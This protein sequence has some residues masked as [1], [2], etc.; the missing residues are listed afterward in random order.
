MTSPARTSR[1]KSLSH[2]PRRR[3]GGGP[4]HVRARHAETGLQRE[5]RVRTGLEIARDVHVTEEIAV[6][7]V[8]CAAEGLDRASHSC[9][10]RPRHVD[11]P[12]P[13]HGP[14]G[15]EEAKCT[16][17]HRRVMH[18]ARAVEIGPRG[19]IGQREI[20]VEDARGLRRDAPHEPDKRREAW[21]ARRP[22]RSR[23][24]RRQDRSR[25]AE[26]S[27][28]PV[29]GTRAAPR[30]GPS[31][32]TPE[33]RRAPRRGGARCRGDGELA[34]FQLGEIGRPHG[35]AELIVERAENCSREGRSASRRTRMGSFPKRVTG[36][37]VSL[38]GAAPA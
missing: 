35:V 18:E 13:A 26:R 32:T 3:T 5:H 22:A 28:K 33:C 12:R 2:G 1:R 23:R 29:A 9:R 20:G 16:R 11:P 10:R 8:D 34:E 37:R 7:G 31:T 24:S 14:E 27:T 30:A 36:I 4:F 6:G 25:S 19:T 21:P 38:N 15:Q 17:R